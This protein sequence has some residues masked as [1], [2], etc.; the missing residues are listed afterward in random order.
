MEGADPTLAYY[1]AAGP[2]GG[3]NEHRAQD[4]CSEQENFATCVL[5]RA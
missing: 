5:V 4:D 3:A 1:P 2:G